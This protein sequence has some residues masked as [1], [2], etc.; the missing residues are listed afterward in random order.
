MR[1]V[2]DDSLL[3]KA[4]P[5]Y[6]HHTHTDILEAKPRYFEYTAKPNS[7]CSDFILSRVF[8]LQESKTT[9]V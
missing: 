4:K 8:D 6:E 2:L 1:T 5:N 9:E 7:Q 3:G